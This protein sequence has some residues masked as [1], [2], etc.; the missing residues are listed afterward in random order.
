MTI[1]C[2]VVGGGVIGMMTARELSITGLKVQIIEKGQVGR[3]ASWAG[4]GILSPIS[5]WD[6]AEEIW[7]MVIASQ[8]VYPELCAEL[9]EETG[10][11]PQWIRSGMLNFDHIDAE[12]LV[13]WQDKTGSGIDYLDRKQI[14]EI[15]PLVNERFQSA[16]WLSDIAQIR[17]PRLLK[18][19]KK[20]LLFH[21]V[22]ISEGVAVTEISKAK[23]NINAVETTQ[24]RI[25]CGAVVITAGAW[26]GKFLKKKSL[27]K[28]I[29]GQ[30]LRVEVPEGLLKSILLKDD[31]YL[32]PRQSEMMKDLSEKKQQ[33]LIG[34]TLEDV[35]FDQTTTTEAAK[36]LYAVGIKVLPS[37]NKF[38]IS[39]QWS[40]LR[41]GSEKGIPVID[42]IENIEGLFLNS[43]HHRNGVTL[44]PAAAKIMKDKI[45][46]Y[47]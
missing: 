35:G 27:I 24:G 36:S 22:V 38:P 1:D 31:I 30:M 28:P 5:P 20:S 29:R 21:G 26:S 37:L 14:C 33:I 11:D 9:I 12:K 47:Y 16:L 42:A 32:I 4:G 46:N 44:A 3:E 39:Q 19:L 40:G 8:R 15:E 43:G 45:I 41:P 2:V 6:A 7:P 23:A 18:A 13:R 17:T 34:S 10:I 25:N